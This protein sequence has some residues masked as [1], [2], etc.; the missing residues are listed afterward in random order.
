MVE[1]LVALALMG[2]LLS[3]GV[4]ALINS[5]HRAK[6][7]AAVREAANAATEA[8]LEAVKRNRPAVL[9]AEVSDG[10]MVSFLDLDDDGVLDNGERV[11]KRFSLP[12]GLKFEAPSADPPAI[13]FPE[14]TPPGPVFRPNGSVE[15]VG[16]LR[17]ADE[18][19]NYFEVRVEP[20]A[21]AKITIRKWLDGEILS[22]DPLAGGTVASG[23]G[24]Y[25]KGEG[26]RAWV[27]N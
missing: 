6:V 12:V 3:F 14:G 7:M 10:S 22:D 23:T 17:I 15:S 2:I 18:R 24:W 19:D 5:L 27:W 9:R 16:A 13:A 20:A 25:A 11:L 1:L 21:S 4:P 8:R 26:N